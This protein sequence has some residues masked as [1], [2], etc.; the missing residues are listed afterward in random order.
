M[1]DLVWRTLVDC[2]DDQGKVC[3]HRDFHSRNLLWGSDQVTRVVDF[4]DA[5]YGPALYDIASLLRDCYVRFDETEIARWRE[6][7]R[8][9]GLAAGL[10]SR[11]TLRQ[12]ARH[13]DMTA[14]QRQL[15]AIG[16]FSRLELRDARPSHLVD[17]APVLASRERRRPRA[18][19]IS[20]D[21]V[22]GSPTRSGRQRRVALA[23][24]GI[25]CAE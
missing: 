8:A 25:E 17:I 21:S 4:Q 2:V 13:L 15:K 10:R 20:R 19:P 5:L 6:R 14:M 23:A 9:R 22:P 16:I 24:R 12:F 11:P 7:F 3:V 1:L 18:T